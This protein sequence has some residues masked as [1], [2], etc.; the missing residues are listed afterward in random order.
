MSTSR[1]TTVH[2]YAILSGKTKVPKKVEAKMGEEGAKMADPKV[3]EPEIS[4][5]SD[6]EESEP[7][8][9]EEMEA[10][11]AE[12]DKEE[13]LL[14]MQNKLKERKAKI[15]SLKKKLVKKEDHGSPAGAAMTSHPPTTIKDGCAHVSKKKPNVEIL[16]D[17]VGPMDAIQLAQFKELSLQVEEHMRKTGTAGLSASCPEELDKL[18]AFK[19]LLEDSQGLESDNPLSML[20]KWATANSKKSGR[21]AKVSD[22]VRKRLEWPHLHLDF[23]AQAETFDQIDLNQLVMGELSILGLNISE[24][25]KKGR[26]ELLRAVVHYARLYQWEAVRDFYGN[27]LEGIEKGKRQWGT[28]ESYRAYE[29]DLFRFQLKEDPYQKQSLKG[30]GGRYKPTGV[31]VNSRPVT[32]RYFC[33]HF[34]TNACS[35]G[36]KHEGYL[37]EKGTSKVTLEHF[38]RKCYNRNNKYLEHAECDSKCPLSSQ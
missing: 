34:Q 29:S 38:C 31:D 7:A 26:L 33:L 24:I 32:C 27:I 36:H 5:V 23:G 25:E 14:A 10:Q 2:N 22:I 4:E 21:V 9:M 30:A 13:A 11:L 37:G 1:G 19:D 8:T 18:G 35:L 16:A 20:G 15:K 6:T 3:P 17:S 28:R 12:L